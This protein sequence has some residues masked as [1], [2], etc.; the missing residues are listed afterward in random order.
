[1]FEN[2]QEIEEAE[3]P[4]WGENTSLKHHDQ[5]KQNEYCYSCQCNGE[6]HPLHDIDS[7]RS[8]SKVSS[9]H[10]PLGILFAFTEHQTRYKRGPAQ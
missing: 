8:P 9:W 5:W 10:F 3:F 7:L 2:V 4:F 6:Q 1:M